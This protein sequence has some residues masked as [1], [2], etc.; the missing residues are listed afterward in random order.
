MQNDGF[1]TGK[2]EEKQQLIEKVEQIVGRYPDSIYS[3]YLK[4]NL[5][6]YK[7]DELRRKEFFQKVMK[8]PKN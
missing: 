5:E 7:A 1:N 4:P 2:E 3:K 8:K 6:K